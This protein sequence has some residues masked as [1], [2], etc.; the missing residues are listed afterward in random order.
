MGIHWCWACRRR[1]LQLQCGATLPPRPRS[2]SCVAICK[3]WAVQSSRHCSS[4]ASSELAFH[5]V[6][7]PCFVIVMLLT[8]HSLPLTDLRMKGPLLARQAVDKSVP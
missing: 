6:N 8:D 2:G 5:D 7:D 4:G 3:C 1:R